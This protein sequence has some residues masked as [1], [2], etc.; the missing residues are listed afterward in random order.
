VLHCVTVCCSMLQYVAVCCIELQCVAACCSVLQYVAVCCSMLQC[1]AMCCSVLQCVAVRC[2]E[3]FWAQARGKSSQTLLSYILYVS[4]TRVTK[5]RHELD[6]STALMSQAKSPLIHSYMCHELE[7]SYTNSCH[8]LMSRTHVTHTGKVSTHSFLCHELDVLTALMSRTLAKSP[9]PLIYSKIFREH[10]SVFS[11]VS[12][13]HV[14]KLC[15]THT[16][17]LI[18]HTYIAFSTEILDDSVSSYICHELMS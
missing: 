5:S 11:H 2:S 6:V 15:H 14:M 4:R 17:H 12:R 7:G 1:V 18:T 13:T 8:E 16:H 10:A 9:L 3:L